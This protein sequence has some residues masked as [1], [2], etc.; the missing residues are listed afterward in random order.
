MAAM[1]NVNIFLGAGNAQVA[2]E[3]ARMSDQIKGSQ[4]EMALEL[5]P[6]PL[7]VKGWVT[8]LAFR[9]A[10]DVYENNQAYYEDRLKS[11]RRAYL[12]VIGSVS[13]L[14]E[15]FTQII[16]PLPDEVEERA[17]WWE[18]ERSKWHSGISKHCSPSLRHLITPTS[19]PEVIKQREANY[20]A[21]APS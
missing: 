6:L 11:D 16:E 12:K 13:E 17:D 18:R 5:M 7:E 3:G 20:R 2:R 21:I 19:K 15:W 1:L 8:P 4:P 10:L 9:Q 14:E